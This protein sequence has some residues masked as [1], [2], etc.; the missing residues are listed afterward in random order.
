MNTARVSNLTF[1]STLKSY[2]ISQAAKDNACKLLKMMDDGTTYSLNPDKSSYTVDV[3]ASINI[4]KKAK[5]TSNHYILPNAK[6]YQEGKYPDFTM[7]IGNKRLD[8]NCQT[9][10][11]LRY[12]TGLFTGLKTLISVTEHYIS[13]MIDNFNNPDV[14]T[15]NTFSFQNNIQKV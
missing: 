1:E 13:K 4:G 12:E 14:L 7:Q 11:I 10:E 6:M 8:V 9:G 5:F 15:K 3:L 2:C